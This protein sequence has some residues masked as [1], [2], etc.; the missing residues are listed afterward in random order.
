MTVEH[1]IRELQAENERLRKALDDVKTLPAV[2]D[3]GH[4]VLE[5]ECDRGIVRIIVG[6]EWSVVRNIYYPVYK[7]Q[8]PSSLE[9][10]PVS[11]VLPL[12]S[13]LFM[14]LPDLYDWE[15]RDGRI[16]KIKEQQ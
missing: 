8:S 7:L 14:G 16:T 1:T 6:A 3:D 2:M 13:W 4:V 9:G 15:Y 10:E 11:V 5:S 12:F